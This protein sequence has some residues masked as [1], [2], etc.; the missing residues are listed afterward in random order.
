MGTVLDIFSLKSAWGKTEAFRGT[1]H[2]TVHIPNI[3][4]IKYRIQNNGKQ[5]FQGY[6]KTQNA[7][8]T[9]NFEGPERLNILQ[10]SPNWSLILAVK[11]SKT[12]GTDLLEKQEFDLTT[13]SRT[14]SYT[15]EYEFM[16]AGEITFT[17]EIVASVVTC[18]DRK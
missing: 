12:I 3:S 13:L 18:T 16:T 5:L 11:K 6:L 4:Y 2:L 10:E 8:F 7:E 17:V 15:E 1:F 9:H 14:T